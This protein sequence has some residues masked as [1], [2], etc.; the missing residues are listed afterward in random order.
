VCSDHFEQVIVIDPDNDVLLDRAKP[1][2]TVQCP[3]GTED[4]APNRRRPRVMQYNSY[5]AGQAIYWAGLRRLF[6]GVDEE[7]KKAGAK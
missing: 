4:L 6:L 2:N 3:W 7:L 1:E 5:H